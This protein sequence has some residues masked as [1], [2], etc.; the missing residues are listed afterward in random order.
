MSNDLDALEA[1]LAALR[2]HEV[3]P[4]LRLGIAELLAVAPPARDWRRWWIA[5]GLAA[6]CL[7]TVLVW[8]VSGPQV[9]PKRVVVP[10]LPPVHVEVAVPPKLAA[11]SAM[12]LNVESELAAST[13]H[14]PVEE[15]SPLT[16]STAFANR[17]D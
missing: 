4:N 13:F 6:A 2:P 8:T 9:N 7:A 5:G 1:E 3:S 15:S 14:W 11:D 16:V 12:M 10:P 17:L